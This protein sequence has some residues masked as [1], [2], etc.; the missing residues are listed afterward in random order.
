MEVQVKDGKA[1]WTDGENSGNWQKIKTN[2][3]GREFITVKGQ[4]HF[5]KEENVG[6]DDY[7][8]KIFDAWWESKYFWDLMHNSE[9]GD[10]YYFR[11]IATGQTKDFFIKR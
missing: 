3:D 2:E 11:Q 5:L 4:C 8:Q 9:E 10:Y 6:L 7:N 1:K